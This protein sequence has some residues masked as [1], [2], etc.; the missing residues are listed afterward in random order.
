MRRIARDDRGQITPWTIVS[1]LIVIIL[2]G[3]V[4]DQGLA[5]S[6]KVRA[7]DIAQAAARA[8]AREVD[9]AGYRQTGTVLLDPAAAQAA[10]RTFLSQAGITGT[11]TA[12]T[13]SVTV[14]IVTSRRSQI[15]HLVGIDSITVTATASATPST[16]VLTGT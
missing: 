1:T 3:L 10:A 11:A 16:G 15:L 5:M 7:F 4:L 2:A 13:A 9:L 12:T 6:D 14:S 8:G